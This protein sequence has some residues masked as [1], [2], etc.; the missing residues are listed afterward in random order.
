M[1]FKE[2]INGFPFTLSL[3]ERYTDKEGEEEGE[4]KV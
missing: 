2:R 4:A 3:T 1:A